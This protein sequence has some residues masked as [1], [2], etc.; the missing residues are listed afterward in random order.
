MSYDSRK[1]AG[2]PPTLPPASAAAA[3]PT[4]QQLI[5]PQPHGQNT[6]ARHYEEPT[7]TAPALSEES[8]QDPSTVSV[9]HLNVSLAIIGLH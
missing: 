2:N 9:E 6:T 1:D 8:K 7:P 3:Q 5:P 4:Y